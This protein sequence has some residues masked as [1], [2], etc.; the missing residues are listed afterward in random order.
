MLRTLAEKVDPKHAA[1][2]VVDVQNDYCHENGACALRGVDVTDIQQMARNVNGL[3]EQAH[4]FGVPVIF[5]RTAQNQWTNSEVWLS[6]RKDI[7][8]QQ[9]PICQENSW[10][11]EYYIVQPGPEDCVVTK[12]RY[13]AFIETDLDL[14]LRSRGIRTLIMTGVATNVCVE[15]TLRDGFMKEYYIVLLDDGCAA[16]TRAEHEATLHNV[17]QYFGEVATIAEVVDCWEK[18]AVTAGASS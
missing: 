3:I 8:V 5:V 13:S 11:A 15:S 7:S 6:R 14:I 12:H 17:R 16:N 9:L 4:R 10:G 2:I 18:A 1:I